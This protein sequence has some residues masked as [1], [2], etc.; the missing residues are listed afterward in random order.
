MKAGQGRTV[1]YMKRGRYAGLDRREGEPNGDLRCN[2][3]S[4]PLSRHQID[5]RIR[6]TTPIMT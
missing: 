4:L 2:A 6:V 1:I 3:Y 5:F